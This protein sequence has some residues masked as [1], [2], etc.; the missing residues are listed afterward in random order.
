MDKLYIIIVAATL[1]LTSCTHVA[2]KESAADYTREIYSPGYAS[3][4]R[5]Y[6]LPDDSTKLALEVFRPDTARITIPSGGFKSLFCMSATYV[7]ALSELGL[8]STITAVSGKN[9]LVNDKVKTRAV[10][11]GYEGAMDYETLLSAKPDLALIYGIGGHSPIEAKLQE[12]A[13]PYVYINDFEE[14][15]PLGRAEWMV[16]LGAL[17]GTDGTEKFNEITSAY[18]SEPGNVPVMINAPYSGSWFI[19]GKDNY[20]SQLISDAGGRI[21]V[22]QPDGPQSGTID[23][24]EALPAIA[25]ATV[26]LNPGQ[27]ATIADLRRLVPKASFSAEVW[28]QTPDFYESGA[29]RPDL[30]VRELKNILNG[31]A[32]D[33]LH[34]FVRLK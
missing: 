17:T 33:S 23:L 20:M 21:T 22:T 2:V 8:D 7:G 6:S 25:E 9:Y 28:S 34:Y 1:C 5:I 32:S 18:N 12:L 11:A 10:D 27:A 14:E 24:E 15:S 4:F 31:S 16:A 3:G 29:A 19:P 13:I 30:V 26:W